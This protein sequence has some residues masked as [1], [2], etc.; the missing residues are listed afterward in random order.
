MVGIPAAAIDHGRSGPTTDHFSIG[1]VLVTPKSRGSV[2]LQ[3]ASPWEA[4][5]VDPNYLADANDSKL[6]IFGLRMAQKLADT[7]SFKNNLGKRVQPANKAITD[8]SD[9]EVGQFLKEHVETTYH[10]SGT[11]SMDKALDPTSLKVKGVD[12]LR[13]CDASVFPHLPAGH[14]QACVVAVAEKF[15]DML[16]AEVV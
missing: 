12:G 11:V 6:L 9:E 16:K 4:P 13:V 3:S 8:M 14:P 10:Y 2:T 1:P 15:A 5:V 7:S